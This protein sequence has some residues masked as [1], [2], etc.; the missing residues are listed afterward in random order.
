[1]AKHLIIVESPAKVKTIK[2]FLG[3][4]FAV[5]ASVG[6][7]RDL[8]GSRLGVDEVSFAPEYRVIPGKEKVVAKLAK[9][10]AGVQD[11]FLAPDPDREGE[12]IAWHV[13]Q[14]LL[15]SLG[16][17]PPPIAR[18]QF[19]EI[20][21][22]AVR[23]ALE[24]PR[25][26]DQKLFDS[27]QA[28]R[29][30]DRI[31]GYKVSPLLWKKVKRGISAGRVQSVALKLIVDREKERLAF[32]PVEYWV[33]KAKVQGQA[34]PAFDLDLAKVGGKKAEVGS[35][36]AAEAV[37]AQARKGKFLVSAVEEKERERHPGP[38][39]I[40]ST[41]QQEA[42]RRLG[43]PAKRTMNIAQRL[44]EGVDLGSLGAQALITYMRTDSV[45]VAPEAVQAAREYI[46]ERFGEAFCPA[47][48]R[49]H[50]TKAG[51]QDAHEA[52]RPVDPTLSPDQVKAAL[53]ADQH[54]I[55]KLIWERFMASQMASARFWDTTV[56][57]K[58][59]TTEWKAKGERLLFA[60]FMAAFGEPQAEAPELP[61]LTAGQALDLV[62]FSKEQKF[63]QPPAR[64]S[65][66]SL[67]KELEDKG[68]GRP[69]TYAAI[70][71]TI[72]DR[73]YVRLAERRF[74]PTDLGMVVSDLLSEH[75]TTLMD[76][77]FTAHMEQ[78]L[79]QVAEGKHDWTALLREFSAE[80]TPAL[81]LA[82]KNMTQVKTGIAS[83]VACAVCGKPMTI[84]FGKAGTFL[85]CTGYPACTNT[86]NFQ[87]NEQ[88][89]IEILEREAPQ[90][91]EI[92]RKCPDCGRGLVIKR[93]RSGSRFIACPGYPDCSHA[94]SFSTGVPCPR[95]GCDG[96]LVEKSTRKGKVFF[97]CSN[98]PRCDFAMWNPPLAE[99]C[100][101]C[102][103]PIL[104]R[105][106]TKAGVRISCPNKPCRYTRSEGGELGEE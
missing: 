2:K 16:D 4:D 48:P 3:K 17:N 58:A 56:L 23:E 93:S 79:D 20:T 71:E 52:I 24:H 36:E 87:R 81:A 89:Q 95:E 13:A 84:K 59:G 43:Y 57:A 104:E 53:P 8:P 94:E 37:E 61:A 12:A 5:E 64:Y 54:R 10:A 21:A 96:T 102:H 18:I 69:S 66:A 33:F 15:E 31:V 83:G 67:V 63:T 9:A 14:L 29:I 91:E 41:L 85:A 49:A 50:K 6:H 55:Y 99:P 38:P 22:R 75:F 77:D 68:I 32:N 62:D 11:I 44:Y 105:K 30:L 46:S 27:Q 90:V 76:V 103:F 45:R 47:K 42:N 106:A 39:F 98:Y 92:G 34:P 80:F 28:R 1:M 51:A 86:K 82:A 40:T 101:A 25:P 35:R 88:G 78:S 19:N 26:L 100:P 65:E 60:G 97:S 70:I 7:V 74:A 73:E 72:Q